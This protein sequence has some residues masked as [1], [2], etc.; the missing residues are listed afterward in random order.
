[1]NCQKTVK[2][3]MARE[4]RNKNYFYSKLV[5][6]Y[7]DDNLNIRILILWLMTFN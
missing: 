5:S 4:Y 1:M 3:S 6:A 2:N 7:F